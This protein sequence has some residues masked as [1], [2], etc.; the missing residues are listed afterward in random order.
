MDD[1]PNLWAK[2]RERLPEDVQE[3]LSSL[4]V[5]AQQ[6]PMNAQS[7]EDIISQAHKKKSEMEAKKR[8]FAIRVGSRELQF[9]S[10]F[11]GMIKWLDKFK[12]IGDVVSSFDP[13]HAALPW[14]AFRFVLQVRRLSMF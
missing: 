3:W 2:A 8:R 11:E 12:G 1:P 7:I 9:R 6:S 5:D 10:H 13:V 14:A 4:D